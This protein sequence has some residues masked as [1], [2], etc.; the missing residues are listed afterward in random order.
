[1][2]RSAAIVSVL[3]AGM[4]AAAIPITRMFPVPIAI[5]IPGL[6]DNAPGHT[7]QESNHQ[8]RFDPIFTHRGCLV[9]GLCLGAW[10]VCARSYPP[11]WLRMFLMINTVAIA[12]LGAI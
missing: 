5:M 9:F 8:Q 2:L 4:P 1:M 7:G 12:I 10:S 11:R 6:Y 3:C